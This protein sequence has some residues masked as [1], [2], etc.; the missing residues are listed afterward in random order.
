MAKRKQKRPSR[1]KKTKMSARAARKPVQ[2]I[3]RHGKVPTAAF[4][5]FLISHLPTQKRTPRMASGGPAG[6]I[7][8]AWG[9]PLRYKG[10]TIKRC[11]KIIT[12]DGQVQTVCEY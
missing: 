8:G 6:G 9:C 11:Y 2:K 3:V 1:A 5:D 7:C 4:N 12:A 10:K